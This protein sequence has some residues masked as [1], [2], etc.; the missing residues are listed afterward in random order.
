MLIIIIFSKLLFLAC[1]TKALCQQCLIAVR[2]L[3]N[4]LY[5]FYQSPS[6]SISP[7]KKH[8]KITPKLV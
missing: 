2:N 5:N 6:I 8:K 4:S 3:K 7:L 1:N